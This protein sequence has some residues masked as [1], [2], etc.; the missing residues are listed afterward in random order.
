MN[1]LLKNLFNLAVLFLLTSCGNQ[2]SEG[3]HTDE[4]QSDTTAT[5]E[6][7]TPPQGEPSERGGITIAPTVED[8]IFEQVDELGADLD[9]EGEFQ[10]GIRWTNGTNLNYLVIATQNTGTF[11][12]KDWK[13]VLLMYHYQAGAESPFLKDSYTDQ[14]SNIYSA[15]VFLKDQT[16]I[17]ALGGDQKAP[18]F[19]YAICPDGED[20]CE[21]HASAVYRGKRFEL[22]RLG[23]ET[24]EDFMTKQKSSLEAIPDALR[25]PLSKLL[26]SVNL[27]E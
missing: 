17:A 21:I 7:T 26:F 14:S 3:T 8:G 24:Q 9:F 12:E 25:D 2:P 5:M 22:Q 10:Q 19:A 11:F 23:N 4:T 16:S 13:S 15:V 20:P 1:Q 27:E 6:T 18:L